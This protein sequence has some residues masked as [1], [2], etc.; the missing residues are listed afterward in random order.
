MTVR[1]VSSNP[2]S[3]YYN[4]SAPT[5]TGQTGS[6]VAVLDAVLVNGFSGFTALGWTIAYTATNKRQYAMAASGTSCQLFIDDSGPGAGGAREARINGFK[7]GTAIGAGTGQFPSTS[8]ISAPSGALVVRK[9]TTADATA[10]VWTIIGDGHTFYMLIET[11][12]QTAPL[13]AYPWMFGDF[14]SYSVSDTNNCIIIGRV[15]ENSGASSS[16]STSTAGN[17][18]DSFAQIGGTTQG[19]STLLSN[20]FVGHYVASQ[21]NGVGS[22]VQVGKHSDLA[23]LGCPGN[24]QMGYQGSWAAGGQTDWIAQ[25]TYPN[26]ADGGLYVAPVWVHHNGMVRGYLK[27]LWCPLQ[28]LPLTHGDTYSGTGNLSGKSILA[29]TILGIRGATPG[30]NPAQVHIE[31]SDTWS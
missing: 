30:I 22:S 29:M 4:A 17:A 11:G 24:G 2:A 12:D 16:G 20:A 5:L 28:H 7:T 3:P 13:M 1:A 15:I 25:F 31:T 27:G 9:S 18:Y 14:F 6:L 10:R 19:S 26:I 8:Q 21:P 23:K